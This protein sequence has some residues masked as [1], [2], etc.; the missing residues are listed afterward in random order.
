M[1]YLRLVMFS[2]NQLSSLGHWYAG[3]EMFGG[4][5]RRARA[6]A[7]RGLHNLASDELH[8]V[9]STQLAR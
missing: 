5:T 9:A 1:V 6:D 7:H 4:D 2:L 8:K 3:A